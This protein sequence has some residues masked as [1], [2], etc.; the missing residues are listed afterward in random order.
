MNLTVASET[1]AKLL[2]TFIL[3]IYLYVVSFH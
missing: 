2:L 3:H 1:D